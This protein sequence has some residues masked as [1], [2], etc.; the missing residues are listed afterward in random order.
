MCFKCRNKLSC[1]IFRLVHEDNFGSCVLTHAFHRL[2]LQDLGQELED[3]LWR[4]SCFLRHLFDTEYPTF[5]YVGSHQSNTLS[6]QFF[7]LGIRLC[8]QNSLY[9]GSLPIV[10]S[11]RP[12]PL[13]SVDLIHRFQDLLRRRNVPDLHALKGKSSILHLWSCFI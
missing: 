8:H 12:S 10:L 2:L 4:D 3:F 5:S 1:L 11:S 9:L 7:F 6:S 13:C